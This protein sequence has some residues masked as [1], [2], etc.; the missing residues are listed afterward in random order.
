M[1]IFWNDD[2]DQEEGLY[3]AT[4]VE[5]IFAFLFGIQIFLVTIRSFKIVGNSTYFGALIRIFKLMLQEIIKFGFIY[6]M[7]M[8]G[9]LF[10]LWFIC[11]INTHDD[12]DAF[13]GKGLSGGFLLIFEIFIGTKE[14]SEFELDAT[15]AVYLVIAS[16]FGTLVLL[17]LLIALMNAKY[18][19][20]QDQ[21]LANVM[22]NHTEVAFDYLGRARHMPPPLNI[23]VYF[24]TFW[25]WLIN[26]ISSCIF[27]KNIFTYVHYDMFD[28]LKNF[29]FW[30]CRTNTTNK[31]HNGEAD[32]SKNKTVEIGKLEYFASMNRKQAFIWY[33][34]QMLNG[35]MIIFDMIASLTLCIADGILPGVN[36]KRFDRVLIHHKG[37]YGCIKIFSNENKSNEYV[38]DGITMSTYF[39]IYEEHKKSSITR[40]D[41]IT[42]TRL[43]SKTLFCSKCYQ[44]FLISDPEE[45]EKELVTPI[46]P[47]LDFVSSITF[48]IFPI[49]WIPLI[50]ITGI[51]ALKDRIFLWFDHSDRTNERYSNQD[52]DRNYFPQFMPQ[53]RE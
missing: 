46:V 6:V 41:R 4:N 24:L 9:V 26:G 53:Y 10:G 38:M 11:G 1:G 36:H 47:L 18:D 12:D 20:V 43:T 19:Q 17:N 5:Q 32:K 35:I 45:L 2:A 16:V 52:Y 3:E 14:I 21:A 44:A 39:G 48:V 23:I 30:C 50:I 49:A 40:Q 29:R 37:C 33:R 42:L 34:N 13:W 27:K 15:A 28:Y 25:V 31:D 22:L 51:G 8:I 7:M